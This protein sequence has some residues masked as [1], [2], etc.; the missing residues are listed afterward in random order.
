MP[1]KFQPPNLPQ[2]KT[3]QEAFNEPVAQAIQGLPSTILAYQQMRRQN[4]AAKME[5][6]LKVAQL[7]QALRQTEGE[8]GTGAPAPIQAGQLTSEPLPT[9]GPEEQMFGF[10]ATMPSLAPE[11]DQ[12]QIARLGTKAF[13]AETDRMKASK[14]NSRTQLRVTDK[15][16]ALIFN[17]GDQSLTVQA[18]GEAYDPALHG[19]FK[20]TPEKREEAKQL[21]KARKD[22][23]AYSSD[24][25]Q[26]LTALDK[27]EKQAEKLP[28]FKPGL[29]NQALGRT[30]A[31]YKSFSKE[32]N[33]TDYLGVVS[34]ELI[35]LARKLMEE[36][37]PITEF[38][39][40][41]VEKGLGDM[42]VP[43]ETKK[44]LLAQMRDKVRQALKNKAEVAEMSEEEVRSKYKTLFNRLDALP[45]APAA[46][47]GG[48]AGSGGGG[49]FKIISVKKK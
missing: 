23:D 8:Y 39:V 41:R 15:D 13:G 33:V 3:K 5:H 14:D 36:K 7:R 43:L 47:N 17:P 32:K 19:S 37:G 26:A 29:L 1:L 34:Q 35:P 31:A 48:Q 12:Q 40:T 25:L 6:D 42:T 4:E 46:E 18:T 45:L 10:E 20:T 44:F 11:S 2:R 22:M 30:E 28:A 9:A 21:S 24:A 16:V 27:I 38:D 49:R